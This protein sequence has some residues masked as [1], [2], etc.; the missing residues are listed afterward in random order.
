MHVRFGSCIGMDVMVEGTS[1]VLGQI[2]GILINPDTAAI[3]GFFLYG[4]QARNQ[5]LF[6]AA[7]DIVRFGTAVMVSDSVAV[8]P[9]EDRVRLRPLLEGK[10]PVL[11]QRI[12]TEQGR[13]LGVSRDVQ[14]TTRA[15]RVEW[16]FPKRLWRWGVALPATVVVKITPAAI[17]V[18]NDAVMRKRSRARLL[19]VEPVLPVVPVP[20][21]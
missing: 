9:A 7:A 11:G 4:G 17:I 15:M 6:L 18:Q 21:T 10:R 13:N 8:A 1:D 2:A 14:F 16:L 20:E 5:P 19:P 12:R 3:E